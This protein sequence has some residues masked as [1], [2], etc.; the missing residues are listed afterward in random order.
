M[1]VD[2]PDVALVTGQG[3]PAK[4]TYAP[5]EQR[6]EKR[7]REDRDLEGLRHA[8]TMSLRADE[9]AVVKHDRAA[10]FELEHG[11]NMQGDRAQ[12]C[13]D[14][15]LRGGRAIR[16]RHARRVAERYVSVHE[17]VGGG[18][19]GDHI[20]DHAA[21]D[22]LRVEG[23]GV[24]TQSDRGGAPLGAPLVD[25]G[26]SLIERLRLVI[27]ISGVQS[28]VDACRVCLNDQRD[29]P[30][31]APGQR[32]RATHASKS[33]GQHEASLEIG[34]SEALG[35]PG[36]DLVG[37]LD[38]ALRAD[39]LPRA[40]GEAAPTDEAAALEVVEH[41]LACPAADHV[42]IGHQDERRT[43]VRTHQRY[44]S[45]RLDDESVPRL[46]GLEGGDNR[47]VGLPVAS[48]LAEGCVDDEVLGVFTDREHVLEQS[49]QP[50]LPP[51]AAAKRSFRCWLHAPSIP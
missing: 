19:V 6:T 4:R 17:I 31:E 36:E 24:A 20:G 38:H 13:S 34:A 40:R 22:D 1:S 8:R 42:A 33:R 51:S 45:A 43:R 39:I 15:L 50:L 25:A 48:G 32:L 29:G 3:H 7:L 41:L 12:A 2:P 21:C 5:A 37:T 14:E 46:H 30:G 11:A 18:L 28:L 35:D 10:R 23:S 47:V 16:A 49:Q 26:Q 9:I 44:G 27:E